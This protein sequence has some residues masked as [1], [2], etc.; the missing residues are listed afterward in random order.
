MRTVPQ[1]IRERMRKQMAEA[2]RQE[3]R[4]AALMDAAVRAY[5]AKKEGKP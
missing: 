4:E 3:E 2:K 5:E 1:W